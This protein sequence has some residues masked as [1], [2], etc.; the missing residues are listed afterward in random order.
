M[1]GGHPAR[2]LL[3]LQ[4][5]VFEVAVIKHSNKMLITLLHIRYLQAVFCFGFLRSQ[6]IIS[7]QNGRF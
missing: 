2:P 5:C 4:N 1:G 3:I 6:A 7:D